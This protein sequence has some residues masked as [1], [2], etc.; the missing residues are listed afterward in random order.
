MRVGEKGMSVLKRKYYT[1]DW[2]KVSREE[3]I[4]KL[5]KIV[6]DYILTNNPLTEEQVEHLDI[7]DIV[8]EIKKKR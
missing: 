2:D 6:I 3:D 1:V 7:H 8:T 5:L 4:K